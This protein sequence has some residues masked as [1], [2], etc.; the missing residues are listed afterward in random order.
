MRPPARIKELP[1]RLKVAGDFIH[2]LAEISLDK[3]LRSDGD[4][5]CSDAV[6]FVA[7]DRDGP[8]AAVPQNAIGDVSSKAIPFLRSKLGVDVA[9]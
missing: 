5:A 2:P 7:V 8:S 6:Q 3:R 1:H 9:L 4:I